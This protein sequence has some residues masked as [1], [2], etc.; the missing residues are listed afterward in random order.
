MTVELKLAPGEFLDRDAD[1]DFSDL[2]DYLAQGKA[3][4]SGEA[5]IDAIAEHIRRIGD[6][7]VLNYKPGA[8]TLQ[9]KEQGII[10]RCLIFETENRD[11]RGKGCVMVGLNPGT[12][13]PAERAFYREKGCSYGAV[14][15]YWPILR[16]ERPYYCRLTDFLDR[17]GLT[18][19]ILWTE[20]VKCESKPDTVLSVQT[21]R[22]DINRY[23]FEEL[24]KIPRDWPL[25]GVGRQAYEILAYRFSEQ[26]VIGIP[27]PT[28]S[29]GQFASLFPRTK[30]ID[31][32][33]K[34]K[35]DELLKS[36]ERVAVWFSCSANKGCHAE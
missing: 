36:K 19:P 27:H 2:G 11:P 16:K 35:L 9:D 28:S 21:I 1:T 34:A 6:E 26:Q 14:R 8:E 7:M 10:P 32:A 25:I 17:V 3:E 18:G 24:K 20:L 23:L 15:D 13:W 31:P 30:I 33:A 22:G 5:E 12:S 29:R 4:P